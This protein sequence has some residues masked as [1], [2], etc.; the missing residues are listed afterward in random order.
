MKR[1]LAKKG[2]AVVCRKGT[3]GLG[4]NVAMRLHDIS[5]DGVRLFIKTALAKG[6][7]VEVSLTP[8]GIS[9]AKVLTAVVAW[10]TAAQEGNGFWAG[11]KFRNPMSYSEIFHLV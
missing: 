10:C 3:M 7:E 4:P 6:D 8:P 1:R 5:E 11:A 2:T 9:K